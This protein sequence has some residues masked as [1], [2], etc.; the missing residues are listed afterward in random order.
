MLAIGWR[1]GVDRLRTASLVPIVLLLY[2]LIHLNG[3]LI[4]HIYSARPL[5][6]QMQQLPATNSTVAVYNT[7]RDIEY[8]LAF[9]RNQRIVNYRND[10]VPLASHLLVAR[11]GS[12]PELD[13]LLGSRQRLFLIHDAAQDLDVFWISPAVTPSATP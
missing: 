13:Q 6:I 2:F 12:D 8:G 1:A 7:R 5:A 3:G 4:D 9:Y 11:T 10:G